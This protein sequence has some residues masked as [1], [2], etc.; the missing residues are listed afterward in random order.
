ML[1]FEPQELKSKGY[2]LTFLG[3]DIAFYFI[4]AYTIYGKEFQR[5]I[6][7]VNIKSLLGQYQFTQRVPAN[8]F[9][10]TS[11]IYIRYNKDFTVNKLLPEN[12]LNESNPEYSQI[13]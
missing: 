10:N 11:I 6:E 13:P 4:K 7:Y 9:E 8:G 1:G 5:C 12:L 2:N 3:F